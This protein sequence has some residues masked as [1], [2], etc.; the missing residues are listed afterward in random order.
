MASPLLPLLDSTGYLSVG[1]LSG[2]DEDDSNEA[3]NLSTMATS[4]YFYHHDD[5]QASSSSEAPATLND[6]TQNR[7][8]SRSG[9]TRH[10]ATSLNDTSTIDNKK[11]EKTF[12]S[13]M[14][15]FNFPASNAHPIRIIP[16][17]LTIVSEILST[18][19]PAT[20]SRTK[21]I[22]NPSLAGDW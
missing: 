19:P 8:I 21:R 14:G 17:E 22:K 2:D 4:D 18:S 15:L 20:L 12:Q 5:E 3:H 16:S 6:S 11:N 13:D 10:L 1:E 9:R 7:L